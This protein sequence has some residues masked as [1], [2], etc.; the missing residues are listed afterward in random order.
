MTMR[1]LLTTTLLISIALLPSSLWA[2]Q[3]G[4]EHQASTGACTAVVFGATS[5]TVAKLQC[6]LFA[7][8]SDAT[9]QVAIKDAKSK[10]KQE[11]N[12]DRIL[13]AS[14]GPYH[15]SCSEAHGAVAGVSPPTGGDFNAAPVDDC[16]VFLYPRFASSKEQAEAQ[17]VQDCVDVATH[18]APR[19][20]AYFQKNC[21]V[22]KSW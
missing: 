15:T 2:Q 12:L 20:V 18:A 16:T 6:K 5:R 11:P 4:N 10:L 9:K 22:L 14:E 7:V 8:G 3:A 1:A 17:A 21:H 13:Q 19:G